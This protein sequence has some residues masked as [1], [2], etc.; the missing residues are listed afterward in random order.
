[1]AAERIAIDSEP[2]RVT[3]NE[4]WVGVLRGNRRLAGLGESSDS[5]GIGGS[6]C[7]GW[8]GVFLQANRLDPLG[9]L[10]LL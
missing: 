7:G 6:C 8:A 1:M 2:V 5:L 10:D 3:M 9:P 4:A